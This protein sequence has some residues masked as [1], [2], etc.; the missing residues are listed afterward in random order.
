MLQKIQRKCN[1]YT[2]YV[3]LYVY[4]FIELFQPLIFL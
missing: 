1:K 2:Y 4:N 3:A